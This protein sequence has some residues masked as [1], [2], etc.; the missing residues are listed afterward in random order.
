MNKFN[1][2]FG[3]AKIV[4]TRFGEKSV[5]SAPATEEF[6]NAWRADKDA[7]KA[8]GLSCGKDDRTGAWRITEWSSP[9]TKEE[10]VEN[11]TASSAAELHTS[12]E[13]PVPAG[14]TYLP[15]QNAGIALASKR[16]NN[17]LAD[18]MGLGKTIQAI[19]VA[20][21]RKAR[22]ILVICPNLV[23]LN[24][25]REIAKW[26]TENLPV[27]VVRAGDAWPREHTGWFIVNYNIAHRYPEVK[28]SAWDLFIADEAHYMKNS[29]AKRT[30]FILGGMDKGARIQGVPARQNL[31]LTGTPIMNRPSELFTLIHRLDPARWPSFYSYATRYCGAYKDR[32][33]FQMGTPAHL[34]ELQA[35]LRDTVMIRRLK[36]D[37]LVDLPA[38][39]RQVIALE[40]DDDARALVAKQL[41]ANAR[42]EQAK[43]RINYAMLKAEELGDDV[44]YAAAARALEE[45]EG[46]EF[47]EMSRIRHEVAL[48][49]V[50]SVV[51]HL[52]SCGEKTVVF[53]WHQDVVHAIAAAV[54]E[55][56]V[57]VITGSTKIEDRQAAVDAFQNDPSVR[58]IVCNLQAG[59][60]GITLTAA[61]HVVCAEVDWVPANITQAED[62]CHRIGQRE[63]VLV[64]HIVLDGSLDARMI[65]TLIDKQDVIDRALD[66]Q[67]TVDVQGKA[68]VPAPSAP[69]APVDPKKAATEALATSLTTDQIQAI[70]EA[71][72]VL[73]SMD[74]DRACDQNMAGFNK[75][76]TMFGC[77]LA[78]KASLSPRQAAVAY[79]MVRKYHR[80]YSPELHARIFTQGEAS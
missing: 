64:Q 18:E 72:R 39:R 68:F 59:G 54:K 62:R 4:M 36:K 45:A 46:A 70:H 50:P 58:F 73:A 67:T 75:M 11:R 20:N 43:A 7:V 56:G 12:V 47:T 27:Y 60:V 32:F 30:K 44:A 42:H 16:A 51:E 57:R 52:E 80:Q 10:R 41:D 24:W 3:P 2:Q 6:W 29:K 48:A 34:D 22:R 78:S 9:M 61:S 33:G 74:T 8:L 40:G 31:F 37:V 79:K 55:E 76:D 21:A 65:N 53:A 23:L 77:E 26:Q 49:K 38:K 28:D 66:R 1:L 71:L 17:L 14:L 19:G 63:S 35:R 13:L 69:A 15:Y 5:R 25:A